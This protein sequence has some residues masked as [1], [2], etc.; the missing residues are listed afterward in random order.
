MKKKET[1][2]KGNSAMV[3]RETSQHGKHRHAIGTTVGALF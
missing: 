1:E 3:E 2:N